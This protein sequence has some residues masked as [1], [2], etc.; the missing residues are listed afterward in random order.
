MRLDKFL[1]ECGIGTRR[2]VKDIITKDVVTINNK[3]VSS[4]KEKVDLGKDVVKIRETI[5]EY[6][7]NRFYVLNKVAG[8]I[9]ATEDPKEK[10]VMELLPKWVNKKDLFPVGRL[11]KDTEGLLLFTNN[12]KIAHELLSPKKHVNKTYLVK[13][14]KEID[15]K[16]VKLLE[17]GVDIGGYVTK[18]SKVQIINNTEI[19]LTISEGRFHQVKKMLES[20]ENKVTYLKR[21]QFGK[22]KLGDLP[23]GEVKEVTLT[24]IF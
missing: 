18:P 21:L 20:V 4:P 13:L 12:G 3:R 8:F 17:E 14:L 22:L 7:E 9:T 5:L 16:S 15:E 24:D 19:F 11:D 2:E 1:T 10:T 6:K 23:L